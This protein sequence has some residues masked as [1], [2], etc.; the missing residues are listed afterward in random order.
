ML[1]A[2]LITAPPFPP[3]HTQSRCVHQWWSRD[4]SL[5][6]TGKGQ[7]GK[8]KSWL[9]LIMF[10]MTMSSI[11][12]FLKC[13]ATTAQG[14][15]FQR[16]QF[17]EVSQKL[18]HHYSHSYGKRV[19]SDCLALTVHVS[20]ASPSKAW[21]QWVKSIK[22]MQPKISLTFRRKQAKENQKHVN[23]TDWEK[24]SISAI[25]PLLVFFTGNM[26]KTLQQFRLSNFL[27]LLE[28]WGLMRIL[29]VTDFSYRSRK[30][31][32]PSG[33]RHVTERSLCETSHT[34]VVN[35]PNS[36]KQY[37]TSCTQVTKPDHLPPE[38]QCVG[39]GIYIVPYCKA[40]C[41]AHP[42]EY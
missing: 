25:S 41:E 12:G 19:S 21:L 5:A 8:C 37:K 42:W 39:H 11:I 7:G 27:K 16:I 26:V 9:L 40:D 35:I 36:Q 23:R 29:V 13:S 1:P 28:H 20:S 32:R 14:Y 24:H 31:S 18:G 4:H 34:Q 38:R 22:F 3:P 10:V 30:D 17:S 15:I 33:Y 2:K 6:D